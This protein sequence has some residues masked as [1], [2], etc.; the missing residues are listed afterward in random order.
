[1]TDRFMLG[2][3]E[4]LALPDLGLAAIKAKVDTGA[5]TSSLHAF[6][7]E[8]FG[9]PDKLKVRFGVNPVPGRDDIAVMCVADVVD[10]REVTSS[11]GEREMRYVITTNV[12]MGARTWPIEITLANRETMAYRM[13]IGRQA[14]VDDMFVDPAASFHQPRLSYK[15]YGSAARS[16]AMDT[17]LRPLNITL[18]TRRPENAT[19]RR[20]MRAAE[21]R[22]HHVTLVD[23]SRVSIY[24]DANDPGMFV[25]GR[26]LPR[27]DAIVMRATG[28]INAFSLAIIRQLQAMGAYAVNPA[29]ALAVVGEPMARRQTLAMQKLPVPDAAVSHADLIGGKL[30]EKHVLADGSGQLSTAA[31]LRFAV[32]GGRALAA[33]E[34]DAVTPLES[35]PEWRDAS[36]SR[37]QRDAARAVAER[38]ARSLGLGLAMVDV[39][40]TR[41]GPMIVDVTAN[42]AFAQIERLTGAALAEALMIHIEQEC[43]TRRPLA[44]G[45]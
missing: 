3:E 34:R 31:L 30:H 24:I 28:A 25:D 26:P 42:L 19:N 2:W 44:A 23:R 7:I 45:N 22:G 33:L 41:Q 35:D 39:T 27:Q 8:P 16:P 18:L 14:I 15:V 21:R 38:A 29:E 9:P 36:Q 1:M 12:S 10:R 37:Q 4:W 13:L 6:N 5:R 17:G 43:R 32:I 11:N 40:E 20:L